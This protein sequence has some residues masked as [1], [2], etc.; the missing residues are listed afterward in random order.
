MRLAILAGALA[1]TLAT[2]CSSSDDPT[3]LPGPL[4]VR[5]R[6]S[7]QPDVVVLAVS[8]RTID[9]ADPFCAPACNVDYLG[10]PGDAAEAIVQQ[11]VAQGNTVV[12]WTYVSSLDSYPDGRFGFLQLLDDLDWIDKNWIQGQTTPTRIQIVAHSHGATWAHVAC[13]V[14]ANVPIEALVSLDAI[15]FQWEADYGPSILAYYAVYGN[16][17]PWD[18][19]TP[20]GEWMVPGFAT[21]FDTGDVAFD[22]VAHNFEVQSD[23]SCALCLLSDQT[24]N[25]RLD[26][27]I[28]GIVTFASTQDDHSG[29]HVPGRESMLWVLDR[30]LELEP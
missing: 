25:A 26:G 24:D 17:W 19:S 14:M 13:S 28:T 5:E 29:V 23:D 16:P 11:H 22:N 8:G 27:S 2:G 9:F 12:L 20:C 30:L 7:T 18:I 21:L 3:P 6:P 4:P 15:C 1:L 10:A